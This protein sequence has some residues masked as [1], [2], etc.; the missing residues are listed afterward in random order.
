MMKAALLV[1]CLG[2]SLTGTTQHFDPEK[3]DLFFDRIEQ[4]GQGMGSFALVKG[5]QVIYSRAFGYASIEDDIPATTETKYR[6]GSV[7]KTFTAVIIL[8]MVNA[9]KLS[10][11][12]PLGQFFPQLP[13][14][15]KITIEQLLRHRSGIHNFG[16]DRSEKYQDVNP[17]SREEVL[18]IFQQAKLD[19]KPGTKADYNN[20][21]YLLLSFIAEE[22]DQMPFAQVLEKRIAEPLQLNN[23]Y[24]DD[25][26]SPSANEAYGYFGE[27]EWTRNANSDAG[28]L[29]GV[30][31]IVSTPLDLA[32]FYF[33]VLNR[34]FFSVDL[35]EEMKRL[36]DGMG[37]GLYRY[38][39]GD[40]HLYGHAGNMGAFSSMAGCFHLKGVSFALCLNGERMPLNDILVD[41]LRIYFGE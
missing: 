23:T 36:E 25:T 5:G 14:A 35:L 39:F 7:S 9:G 26:I 19:F 41:A 18:E 38:P 11:S 2:L 15:D 37:M 16:N 20:A 4:K 27:S 31:G 17:Q 13:G 10:L 3:L 28:F 34:P 40:Q 29:L 12:T 30:G 22:V 1:I 8:E 6:I 24:V 21:N 32:S 33:A